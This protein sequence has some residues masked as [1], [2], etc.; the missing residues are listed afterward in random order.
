MGWWQNFSRDITDGRCWNQCHSS[1]APT[2]APR[3]FPPLPPEPSR[4]LPGAGCSPQSPGV[5]ECLVSPLVAGLQNPRGSAPQ[6]TRSWALRL[7]Q[8]RREEGSGQWR[9]LAWCPPA[10][11]RTFCIFCLVQK[12]E[13]RS[14]LLTLLCPGLP[15]ACG[16]GGG[17]GTRW[18]LGSGSAVLRCC[19]PGSPVSTTPSPSKM[20]GSP[21]GAHSGVGAPGPE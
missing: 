3:L 12:S 1:D 18:L 14:L 13:P 4:G 19:A 2:S 8:V 7:Q 17:M 21:V 10:C 6:G 16:Q 5:S 9:S 11:V 20:L 15:D